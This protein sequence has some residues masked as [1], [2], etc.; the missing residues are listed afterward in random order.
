MAE[1]KTLVALRKYKTNLDKRM[2]G[3]E[4]R[5][6]AF[7]KV[8]QET[9]TAANKQAEDT[10]HRTV[11]TQ[12]DVV[13]ERFRDI[14][15]VDLGKIHKE[16]VAYQTF[17]NTNVV[18][19]IGGLAAKD[20][21]YEQT[22]ADILG[23]LEY[24]QKM[25]REVGENLSGS[26]ADTARTLDAKIAEVFD[27]L[28]SDFQGRLGAVE[29]RLKTQEI[30]GSGV[31]KVLDELPNANLTT[32]LEEL[33]AVLDSALAWGGDFIDGQR[34]K[35]NT[36]YSFAGSA[37]VCLRDTKTSPNDLNQNDWRLFPTGG[38]GGGFT[39]RTA[40]ISTG[41]GGSIPPGGSAGQF[42]KKNS[43]TDQDASWSDLVDG[44]VF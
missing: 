39:N 32:R 19:K 33:P 22:Q 14:F 18:G 28:R 11:V 16:L 34:S 24:L 36:I 12:L 44:G 25:S 30:Y 29:E 10:A 31:K 6:I 38:V 13:E 37:W 17:V 8:V 40:A 26:L 1:G 35:K 15:S 3:L 27:T 5:M 9:T 2:V 43:S 42:L 7:N 41:G 20:V 4:S 21:A 23:R